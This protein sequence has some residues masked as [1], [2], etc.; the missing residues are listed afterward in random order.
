MNWVP[1][2]SILRPGIARTPRAQI[3][4]SKTPADIEEKATP[5]RSR[6]F[7]LS[8]CQRAEA[9]TGKQGILTTRTEKAPGKKRKTKKLITE[10]FNQVENNAVQIVKALYD[11][12][13]EGHVLSAKLLVELAEGDTDLD[14]TINKR[15]FNSLALRI[16]NEPEWKGP[17]FVVEEIPDDDEEEETAEEQPEEAQD[18]PAIA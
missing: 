5:M 8:A 3:A 16:A 1:Q 12:T 10:A 18:Q 2:V 14:E 9:G 13:I 7:L 11:S 17:P 15:P 6:L 4:R